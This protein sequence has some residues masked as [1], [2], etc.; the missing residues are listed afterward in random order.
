MGNA[1]IEM[2]MDFSAIEN[3]KTTLIYIIELAF[4]HKFANR[5]LFFTRG[6]IF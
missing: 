2:P 4:P 3:A 1:K 5:L 6:Q